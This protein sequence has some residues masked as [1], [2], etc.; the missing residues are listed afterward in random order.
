MA[1]QS[2]LGFG[3]LGM[4]AW[5]GLLWLI[6]L[7]TKN[8]GIVDFGWCSGLALLGLFYAVAGSG[9][10]HRRI[11][12]AVM[13]V[14]WSGRLAFH[15]LQRLMNGPEDPRYAAIRQSPLANFGPRFLAFFQFQALLAV[16]VSYPFACLA[17]YDN[18]Q[19]T[20]AEKFGTLL[21]VIAFAG[22]SVADAQLNVFKRDPSHKGKT[23]QAGLWKYSRH[24]NYF[25]EWLVWIAFFI[26]ALPAPHGWFSI[27][28]PVIMLF[29]LYKV[30][31]IP[32]TEE[33]AVRS[34]SD[35]REYQRTTSPFIPW[36][37]KA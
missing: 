6:H 24:P 13:V 16:L 1:L 7:K 8:A 4:V 15:V 14:L 22:E 34:R 33:H 35:Y 27:A 28:S 3:L 20:L 2:L 19:L 10:S 26:A 11:H 25:F 32:A 9:F 17:Q 29:F 5:M 31:G 21:W 36:F 37:K 23:C 18:P 30:T 12:M